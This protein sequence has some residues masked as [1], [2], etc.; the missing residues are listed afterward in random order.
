MP[1]TTILT[2]ILKLH[3][4]NWHLS[5]VKCL[6]YIIAGLFKVKTVNFTE[7][8]TTFPGACRT[9]VELSTTPTILPTCRV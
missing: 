8:A 9:R 3:F 4:A 5:R 7:I 6:A 2:N 1:Q